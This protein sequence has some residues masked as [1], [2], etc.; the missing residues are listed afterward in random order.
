MGLITASEAT[1]TNTFGCTNVFTRTWTAHDGCGNSTNRS[2]TITVIDT[3]A[4]AVTTEQGA[5]AV[6]ECP[7]EPS[8]SAPTFMDACAGPVTPSEVTVTNTSGCSNLITRTWTANDGCGNSTN[9]SQTITVVVCT[10][11]PVITYT[12]TSSGTWTLNWSGPC[13]RLQTNSLSVGITTNWSDWF[14]YPGGTNPPVTVT[15]D[16]AIPCVFYRLVWP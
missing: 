4:P 6:I 2:Q 7:A 13:F 8:F 16:P 3:T 11:P 12:N 9:R 10:T 14:D 15:I 1:E 5:D